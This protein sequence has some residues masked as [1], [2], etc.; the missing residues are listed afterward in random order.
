[1]GGM[2]QELVRQLGFTV[3]SIEVWIAISLAVLATALFT[4][5]GSWVYR[6]M[7]LFPRDATVVERTGISLSL[8]SMILISWYAA[9]ASGG[10]SSF[11][12]VAISF[13]VIVGL[14]AIRRRRPQPRD[15]D[16]VSAT[17]SPDERKRVIGIAIFA[18]A[19][20]AITALLYGSTMATRATDDGTPVEFMDTAFYSVLGR[21]IGI[22]GVENSHSPS[23]IGLT[24]EA[25]PQIW[26]HWGEMW[27]A[28][29]AI[30]LTD[31]GAVDARHFIALPI[32]LL[33]A[34]MSTGSLVMRLS[35][36]RSWRPFAFGVAVCVA[37]APV[38]IVTVPYF[39]YWATGLLFGITHYGLAAVAILVTIYHLAIM[40]GR[41]PDWFQA[42]LVAVA[43]AAVLPS[44][45][46]LALEGVFGLVVAILVIVLTRRPTRDV[47]DGLLRTWDRPIAWL[48]VVVS[49]SIIWG[50][51]TGHG[52]GGSAPSQGISP[53]DP[54]WRDS[55]LVIA[56]G[57]G[58]LYAIPL[59]LVRS[60]R[61]E[62]SLL[63]AYAAVV[64]IVVASAL[65]W[66]WRLADFNMFHVFF[67][68]LAVY[69][70]P[71]AAVA[72]WS[73]ARRRRRLGRRSVGVI[74]LV[75]GVLQMEMSLGF[76]I[77]RLQR[78]G[79]GE[80]L[81]IPAPIIAA[82]RDLPPEAMIAYRCQELV[83]IGVWDP[84]L[85]SIDAHT[86]RRIIP[87]CFQADHLRT[88]NGAPAD[89][90]V[91]SPFFVLAHQRE[92][93]PDATAAPSEGEVEA[94]LRRFGVLYILSDALHPT[95]IE[96]APVIVETPTYS[97]QRL[98]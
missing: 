94:F 11:T 4:L 42:G 56:L 69:A 72:A 28:A 67:G 22:N 88:L 92:I 35:G 82:I 73:I 3:T 65:A 17:S 63:P 79:P 50:W 89:P 12:P 29:A 74:I 8:G 45:I 38:P 58:L 27:L 36:G 24:A 1:M 15:R 76:T 7:D 37:L 51:L 40:P 66:G 90:E 71:F 62:G 86:G 6:R 68:A 43:A 85:V 95:L 78:F 21:D 59:E 49:V 31:T 13:A 34:A 25:S 98:P 93:Y 57:A 55:L 64:A 2:I 5:V 46:V 44:H 32:L 60:R 18:V 20:L 23:G 19:F 41:R 54:A 33:A 14:A 26:Y 70:T 48:A 97:L 83:E 84:R 52:I 91:E 61:A 10:G 9:L 53:F 30:E 96:H 16:P 87:M 81:P 47:I 77:A 39:A 80:Y 75:L